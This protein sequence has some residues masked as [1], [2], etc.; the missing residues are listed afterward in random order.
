MAGLRGMMRRPQEVQLCGTSVAL[1][2]VAHYFKTLQIDTAAGNDEMYAC[3][4]STALWLLG[5]IAFQ[6]AVL[7]CKAKSDAESLA[8]DLAAAGHSAACLSSAKDQ[9]ER[10]H[11]VNALRTYHLRIV[12]AT[13]VA[14]RGVDFDR[15]D[16]VVNIDLPQDPETLM[17]RLGRAGRFGRYG[18]AITLV[19]GGTEARR[20]H[21]AIGE[22]AGGQVSC[23]FDMICFVVQ[24]LQ[25]VC[26]NF[27]LKNMY[28]S[29]TPPAG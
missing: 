25:L 7:F 28:A 1:L 12:V 2:G 19:R 21:E 27:F 26:L 15:V 16:L 9:L 18:T 24:I 8:R 20:L 17:H 23:C 14:A 5:G 29:G 13:D 10:I 22:V 6:Q 3:K 11:I 4:L